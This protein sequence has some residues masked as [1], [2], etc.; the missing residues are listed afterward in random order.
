MGAHACPTAQPQ[1]LD[2]GTRS[3]TD[4]AE[5]YKEKRQGESGEWKGDGWGGSP[6]H[7]AAPVVVARAD[8]S[9]KQWRTLNENLG[10]AN[11]FTTC[12][13]NNVMVYF[14]TLHYIYGFFFLIKM[15]QN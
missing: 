7:A 1:E 9:E 14:L 5:S 2:T 15:Q 11:L 10:G 3:A 4:R 13:P 6:D 8:W 12:I